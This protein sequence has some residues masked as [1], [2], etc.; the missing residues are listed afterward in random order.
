MFDF[1]EAVASD[2]EEC[3]CGYYGEMDV[4]PTVYGAEV[5]CPACGASY[6]VEPHEAPL[7]PRGL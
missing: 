6:D 3:M 5:T 4:I 7:D 1:I 2:R